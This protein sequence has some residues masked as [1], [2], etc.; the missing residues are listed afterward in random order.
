[1]GYMA[2]DEKNEVLTAKSFG[3]VL[4]EGGHSGRSVLLA[5]VRH[6]LLLVAGLL[7]GAVFVVWLMERSFRGDGAF[8]VEFKQLQI[9]ALTVPLVSL[10]AATLVL[11]LVDLFLVRKNRLAAGL[12]L[13]GIVCFAIGGFAVTVWVQLPIN[14]QIAGWSAQAPPEGWEE[15]ATRWGRAHDLRTLFSVLGFGLLLSSAAVPVRGPAAG[16]LRDTKGK[17]GRT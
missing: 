13:A 17:E 1:M 5:V 15:L 11:G 10:G 2:V 8:Y 7:A 6:A 16:S 3:V 14:E 4:G 12:A 9:S